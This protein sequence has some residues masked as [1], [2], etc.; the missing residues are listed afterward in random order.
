LLRTILV[1]SLLFL[2]FQSIA[3]AVLDTIIAFIFLII[4]AIYVLKI[5]KVRIKLHK[6]EWSLFKEVTRFSFF[7]F[8]IM[9][10]DQINWKV[11]QLIIGMSLDTESVAIYSIAIQ[12]PVYYM[13]LS[14]AISGVFQPRAMQ[15][16]AKNASNIELTDLLTKTARMQWVIM[17]LVLTGFILFGKQ[18]I[19]LW[20]G[21]EFILA[22]YIAIIIML[23]LT[24]TLLQ[25]VGYFILQAKNRHAF[26]AYTYLSFAIFNVVIT[27]ILVNKYGI[28]GAAVGTAISFFAGNIIVMNL[29]YHFKLKLDMKRFFKDTCKGLLLPTFISITAG[30]LI[31]CIPGYSWMELVLKIFIY[32]ILYCLFFWFLGLNSDE[33][34]AVRY[35]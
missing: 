6:F 2:G 27:V 5:L 25:T 19:I 12:F 33:R 34:G 26:R 22:Y 32:S 14:T 29:Y 16:V 9:L 18:F 20:L 4:Q 35:L 30:I 24:L 7:I 21:N 28:I 11:D 3:I 1:I 23:P 31:N 10:V 17:G 8:I 15:M 13:M